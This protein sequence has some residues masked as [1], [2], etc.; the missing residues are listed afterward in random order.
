MKRLLF[1]PVMLMSLSPVQVNAHPLSL[2]ERAIDL[3]I[4]KHDK[5]LKKSLEGTGKNPAY[6]AWTD[7]DCNV[8]I[9]AGTHQPA[10]F[11]TLEWFDV[12]VCTKTVEKV[13]LLRGGC[14]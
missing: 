5:R 13:C 1:V 14:E 7:D 12:N 4:E 2:E 10:T 6:M 9:K 3:V 8:R 11:S